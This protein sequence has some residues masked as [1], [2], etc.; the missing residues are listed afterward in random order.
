MPSW[1]HI[2]QDDGMDA[3][4]RRN[5]ALA[6]AEGNRFCVVAAGWA[7]ST[8][9]EIGHGVIHPRMPPEGRIVQIRNRTG[10]MTAVSAR[11]R[12]AP[13]STCSP[14]ASERSP[15]SSSPSAAVTSPSPRSRSVYLALARRPR[16]LLG[17]AFDIGMGMADTFQINGGDYSP[18]SYRHAQLSRRSSR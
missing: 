5:L 1:R 16:L 18:G 2:R 8:A 12:P 14:A 6:V 17:G 13:R 9:W 3:H 10:A 7:A 15:R 11:G 4:Q